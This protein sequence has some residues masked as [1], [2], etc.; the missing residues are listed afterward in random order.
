MMINWK[1]V[2]GRFFLVSETKNWG[3]LTNWRSPL[4]L[5]VETAEV[6]PSSDTEYTA[7]SCNGGFSFN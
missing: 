7:V 6:Y 4:N 3:F 1:E 5:S 2:Q